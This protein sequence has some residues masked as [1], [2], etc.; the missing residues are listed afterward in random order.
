[1]KS[2]SSKIL[3]L[4]EHIVNLGA[5]ALAIPYDSF[6][7]K[8][9]YDALHN[10]FVNESPDILRAI[11]AYI[12]KDEDLRKHYHLELFEQDLAKDLGFHMNIPI[13]YGLGSSGALVAAVFD[14][15][16]KRKYKKEDTL[17]KILGQTESFFHGKS[18]GLDPLVSYLNCNVWIGSETKVVK[19]ELDW[20]SNFE[21]F[22]VN[23]NQPRKTGPLVEAFLE[24]A[25]N[26]ELFNAILMEELIPTS[27]KLVSNFLHN[28]HD[29]TMTHIEQLS[30]LQLR[31]FQELILPEHIDLWMLGLASKEYYLKICG[32]GGGGFMLGF[33][34]DKNIKLPFEVIWI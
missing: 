30:T 6:Y 29:D 24:K 26:D 7:C 22:L 5:E 31:H 20:K 11:K 12:A 32:A 34:H 16:G 3:L 4:G 25:S 14:R 23:T 10:D 2:F 9:S 1:M 33:T 19:Q 8:L 17:K 27:N 28:N 15:Y 13:G 18:S 21:I